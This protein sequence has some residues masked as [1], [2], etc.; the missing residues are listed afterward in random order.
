MESGRRGHSKNRQTLGPRKRSPTK[1]SKGQESWPRRWLQRPATWVITVSLAALIGA[2]AQWLPSR[3]GPIVEDRLSGE[4]PLHVLAHYERQADQGV[5]WAIPQQ[6]EVS[7][8]EAP[9]DFASSGIEAF[10]RWVTSNGGIDVGVSHI[11][12]VVTGRRNQPVVITGMNAH[13]LR[14]AEPL[15]KTLFWGASEG[16]ADTINVGFNLDE[17]NPIARR[18]AEDL[19]SLA[20]PYFAN[21]AV[22][23]AKGEQLVFNI[24]ARTD[25]C[26]CL[27]E[28]VLNMVV[29]GKAITMT[30]RD[31]TEPFRVTAFAPEF[32]MYEAIYRA[33]L[34]RGR[35]VRV[36][37]TTF[38]TVGNTPCS[39][40]PVES[41]ECP[42]Q[43]L[44]PYCLVGRSR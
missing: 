1:A 23:V 44:K 38:C 20:E 42:A 2:I 31:T 7:S 39:D 37:P 16:S 35:F 21:H 43:D 10:D 14:R 32:S 29:D 15:R 3:Y 24:V 25:R 30:V 41:F 28:I 4:A 12:L 22:T 9:L 17:V 6:L 40:L 8:P 26:D 27:W 36:E 34:E 5:T 13:V 33:D 18:V 11:K 19:E